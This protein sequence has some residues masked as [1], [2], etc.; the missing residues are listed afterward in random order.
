MLKLRFCTITI[1]ILIGYVNLA[2]AAYSQSSVAEMVAA[3]EWFDTLN[4]PTISSLPFIQVAGGIWYGEETKAPVTHHRFGFLVKDEGEIFSVFF[5][6]LTTET[7]RKSPP[8][9]SGPRRVGYDLVDIKAWAKSRISLLNTPRWSVETKGDFE[10]LVDRSVQMFVVSRACA[11][12]GNVS[13]GCELYKSV[14]DAASHSTEFS[15]NPSRA[16]LANRMALACIWTAIL[17]FDDLKT[18]RAQILEDYK[19]V[20]TRFPQA[21]Y[22]EDAR[23]KATI[24]TGM[25]AEDQE[26]AAR[27]KMSYDKLTDTEKVA[28]LIFQLRDQNGQQI[29]QPGWVDLFDDPRGENSPAA[30][31]VKL[32]PVA[33]PQLIQA[34]DD[35]RFTRSLH[36][37]RGF[38]YSHSL[39]RVRDASLCILERIAN[40]RF[41]PKPGPREW[42]DDTVQFAAYKSVVKAWW[43]EFIR[44]GEKRALA[45][46]VAT[47]DENAGSQAKVLVT[48]YP[49]AALKAIM[50]GI[51]NA[52]T[53]GNA[54][55]LVDT[56]GELEGADC[57]AFL[58]SQ[59]K[60][61]RFLSARIAAAFSLLMH[62]DRSGLPQMIAEW[63]NFKPTEG[64]EASQDQDGEQLVTY[65]RN[66]G[67]S[68]GIE[69]LD[70]HLVRRP[71]R[72]RY[73]AIRA[74]MGGEFR[75]I[76]SGRYPLTRLDAVDKPRARAEDR[77]VEA[78]IANELMDK[79]MWPE[80]FGT[81]EAS[82]SYPRICDVAA[83]ALADLWPNKYRYRTGG[84]LFER[85][86]QCLNSYNAFA[87]SRGLRSVEMPARPKIAPAPLG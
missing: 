52:T 20:L 13:L 71:L 26:H 7:F 6:D 49:D 81:G 39:L 87:K 18:T 79:E 59:T 19:S 75:Y 15:D 12:A 55:S 24:L 65:L 54:T 21:S 74:L 31:L 29:V 57:L 4:Y 42:P 28:E 53:A 76:L 83:Y 86:T 32:G 27:P 41:D 16:G 61:S 37:V 50:P 10:G 64:V 47:G 43:E 14:N 58:R 69:A 80:A 73:E 51:Q 2:P 1:F 85:D 84:S 35:Q 9:V 72:L 36:F 82:L 25:V 56:L 46:A 70:E 3:Y 33:V 48:R 44:I 78:L 40:R 45:E 11:G 63:R 60:E 23:E 68:R 22:A 62:G 34:L 30:R 17:K 38:F 5:P 66:V 67:E 77:A 8:T